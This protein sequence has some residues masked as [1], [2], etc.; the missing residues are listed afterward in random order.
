MIDFKKVFEQ[1]GVTKHENILI[2]SDINK[3]LIYFKR[4]KINFDPNTIIEAIIEIVGNNGTLMFPTYNWDF[5]EGKIFDYNRTPSRSGSLSKA[6]LKRTDFKRSK[7]PIYSFAIFG[8]NR[9]YLTNLKH[10]N[11]FDLNSP[12]GF[13][14]K[15]KG[16]NLFIDIDYKESLT[17]VHVAEQTVGVAYRYL[18]NFSSY[19]KDESGNKSLV[20]YQM[21]VRNE[22][23]EGSTAIDK[24]MD[25]ELENKGA[26]K[27]LVMNNISFTL[28]DISVAYHI[29]LEDI[30]KKT[31][32]VY[33][34]RS[35][36]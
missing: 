17:F 4:N 15:N 9:E 10:E 19:Y 7:N 31:G 34:K 5:C 36:V 30:K 29:M 11:S 1:L 25:Q 26:I 12:F 16:K 24:K 23:F 14:I 27:S 21:Y 33:P 32:I 8:K 3:I 35:N 20:S 18:K 6:A 13:L 22:D 28:V 2:N